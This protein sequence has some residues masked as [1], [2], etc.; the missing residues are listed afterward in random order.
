MII[1]DDR[2]DELAE[3]MIEAF[4]CRQCGSMNVD[5]GA[6]HFDENVCG[7]CGYAFYDEEAK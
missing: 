1:D 3:A 2:I 7:D 6:G 5:P 4:R